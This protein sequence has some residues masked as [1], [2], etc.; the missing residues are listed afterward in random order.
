M[1]GSDFMSETKGE[2]SFATNNIVDSIFMSN[3]ICR[4]DPYGARNTIVVDYNDGS[5]VISEPCLNRRSS[6]VAKKYRCLNRYLARVE[7]Y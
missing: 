6:R 3:E 5:R 2:R 4:F 1:A 7:G